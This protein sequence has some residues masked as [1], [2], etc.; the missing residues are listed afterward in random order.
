M[1]VKITPTRSS[2]KAEIRDIDL[3]W[4]P[5]P[6]EKFISY[7]NE[8]SKGIEDPIVVFEAHQDDPG[9][10]YICGL[11]PKTP[12]EIKRDIEKSKKSKINKRKHRELQKKTREQEEVEQLEELAK[13]HG[14][15]LQRESLI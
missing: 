2:F 11:V 13:K 8:K 5:E 9:E 12:E 4:Q 10:M 1:T 15:I 7:L 14:F 3:P 6:L